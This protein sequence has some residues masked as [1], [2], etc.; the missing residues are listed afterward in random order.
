MSATVL[1]TGANRGI[2]I[3]FTQHYLNAG[4]RVFACCRSPE[5]ASELLL[6]KQEHPDQLEIIPLDVNKELRERSK[7]E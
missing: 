1:I 3:G 2:G 4:Y 5:R 6:M 7:S